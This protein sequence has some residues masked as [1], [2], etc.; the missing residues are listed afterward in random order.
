MKEMIYEMADALC[1]PSS[2]EEK[3]ALS[4]LCTAVQAQVSARF[5]RGVCAADCEAAFVCACACLA[6][7]G[8]QD[9]RVRD[10]EAQSLRVGDVS[11]AFAAGGDRRTETLR[12]Q[13]QML[14]APYMASEFAF[15]GVKG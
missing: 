14:L 15:C 7:A 5:R 3:R 4:L 12:R 8:M 10:G 1:A 2:E 9:M 6:A 11:I 13:A